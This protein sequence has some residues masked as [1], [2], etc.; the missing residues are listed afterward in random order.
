MATGP[1]VRNVA[2]G[3]GR[4]YAVWRRSQAPY[5]E[6]LPYFATKYTATI[7]GRNGGPETIYNGTFGGDADV[8]WLAGSVPSEWTGEL[9]DKLAKSQAEAYDRFA[10]KVKKTASLATSLAEANRSLSMIEA[11]ALQLFRAARALK[12]GD[13]RGLAIQL[14]LNPERVRRRVE[15]L[16]PKAK[17]LANVWLEFT[18]GWAPLLS[19]IASCVEVLQQDFPISPIKGRSSFT[20]SSTNN[21]SDSWA[22][23]KTNERSVTVKVQY[24]GSVRITNSNLLLAN[25]LGFV[26]PVSVA[27]ELVPFSFV[28]DW[29][30]PVGRF[31]ESFTDFVG[32]SLEQTAYTITRE[33]TGSSRASHI[34]SPAEYYSQSKTKVNTVERFIGVNLNPPNLTARLRLPKASAWLAAT[35]ISL[36]VQQLSSLKKS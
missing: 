11:R 1:Y 14:S 3:N 30:L 26:N 21:I 27:W 32:L 23:L 8:M 16:G 12:R 24:R 20:V 17:D 35:S 34:Y 6:Q 29:F 7:Q 5:K 15:K 22:W 9:G 36:A 31:L 25:S 4:E 2:T 33:A 13:L 19:D 10:N 18:F 28:V